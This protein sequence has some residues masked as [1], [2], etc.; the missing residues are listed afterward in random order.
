MKT[1]DSAAKNSG[2]KQSRTGDLYRLAAVL[3]ITALTYLGTIR[4]GFVYDDFQQIL[5]NPFLKSWRYV[6][7]YFVSSVWKQLFPFDP[8]NYYRP[9]FLF[10]TRLNYSVFA[11]RPMGW[12]AT[13]I[14]LHVLVTA[15]VFFVVRKMTGRS[16]AAWLTALIFGL[17]PIHHEVVAWVSGTTESLFAAMFLAAFLAYLRARERSNGEGSKAVWMSASCVFYALAMLS[18]ETAI[19]LPALVFAHSWIT[20]APQGETG[21]ARNKPR[22]ARASM[23]T[24]FY[25]PIAM[26]YLAV[27]Y[28]ALSG[29]DHMAPNATFSVW[30]MTL[31]SVLVF[32][33][34]NWFFPW[35]LSEDY[36]LFY[37]LQP[38]FAHVI[39]PA[40]ILAVI[41]ALLWMLWNYAGSRDSA[42]SLAWIIIPL[43]PALDFVVFRQGQLVHDRYFYVPS[44]GA[45]LLI[46]LVVERAGNAGRI[47]FGQQLHTVVAALALAV[48]LAICTTWETSYWRDDF[49]LFS[50][51]HEIAPGNPDAINNLGVVL[52][53][54]RQINQ[55]QALF[56]AGLK[57]D[58][59]NALFLFN[60]GRLQYIKGDYSDAEKYTRKAISFNPGAAD[61]YVEL[62]K[63]QLKREDPADASSSFKRAVELDPYDPNF[64]TSYGI[65]LALNGDCT[66]AIGQFESALALSP[67]DSITKMELESCHKPQIPESAADGIAAQ[68]HSNPIQ[69][70]FDVS[71]VAPGVAAK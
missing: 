12:H 70:G 13:A 4:F 30:L 16:T 68:S 5:S 54:R 65:V 18:K 20:D 34:K 64:H 7:Q 57:E 63:I 67:G 43:L 22:L 39:L 53:E 36:D 42:Y 50:R 66:D 24:A 44:I 41:A 58:S 11:D 60:E 69:W 15:L 14:A 51:A 6:P 2:F 59:T 27:R 8:G 56:D 29:L 10:W 35:H 38:N 26:I 19:V 21:T 37:Q 25:V 48:V 61:S 55:A 1:T 46:A 71:Q 49:T 52:I 40:L 3:F 33:V 28:Q 17:H 32:Y 23:W 31:P 47:V 62:G 45:A 9:L